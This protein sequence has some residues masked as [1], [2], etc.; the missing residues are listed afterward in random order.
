MID[1]SYQSVTN[2]EFSGAWLSPDSE[3]LPMPSRHDVMNG[4]NGN[5]EVPSDSRA[6]LA[7]GVPSANFQHLLSYQ[8][9]FWVTI[10]F[11]CFLWMQMSPVAFSRSLVYSLRQ[12]IIAAGFHAPTLRSLLHIAEIRSW[13][14]MGVV[15]AWGIIAIVAYQGLAWV[16]PS[17]QEICYSVSAKLDA[18]SVKAGVLDPTSPRPTLGE[19]SEFHPRPKTGNIFS[20]QF[21]DRSTLIGRHWTSLQ[22]GAL[23]AAACLVLRGLFLFYTTLRPI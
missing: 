21:W 6:R 3:M 5:R 16:Y 13:V 19:Y 22:V 15:A 4:L 17:R 9:G 23:A 20:G 1:P 10:A 7:I 8:F 18:L 2:K 12:P 14:Q 11:G